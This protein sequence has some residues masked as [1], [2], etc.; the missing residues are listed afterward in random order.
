MESEISD[1][2][3]KGQQEENKDKNSQEAEK[4]LED[5]NPETTKKVELGGE[6]RSLGKLQASQHYMTES[7]HQ[8]P[9]TK[10]R[11]VGYVIEKVA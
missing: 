4:K 11:T 9:K 6:K 7:K 5:S 10:E 8:T 2:C 1:S 3:S